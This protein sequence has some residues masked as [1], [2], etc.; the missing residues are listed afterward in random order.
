MHAGESQDTQGQPGI[1]VAALGNSG[2]LPGG[3]V[4]A[5]LSL[6]VGSVVAT[7]AIWADGVLQPPMWAHLVITVPATVA[8]V[9]FALRRRG[10][11]GVDAE[12]A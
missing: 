9:T 5:L 11:A 12:D 1:P 8:A 2:T 10:T 6:A 3:R 7:L 4:G